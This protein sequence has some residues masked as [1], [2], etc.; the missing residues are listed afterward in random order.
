MNPG[1]S[2][3]MGGYNGYPP[4]LL[5]GG[6]SQFNVTGIVGAGGGFA[7]PPGSQVTQMMDTLNNQVASATQGP[8]GGS[9]VDWAQSLAA[10]QQAQPQ[11]PQQ[12]GPGG[13]GSGVELIGMLLG[14]L[15]QAVAEKLKAQK[16][17]DE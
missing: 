17:E 9:V 7:Y 8:Y 12:G 2:P 11:Q 5:P 4:S 16:A 15:L 14:V 1:F 6:F 13:G 10:G 3:V